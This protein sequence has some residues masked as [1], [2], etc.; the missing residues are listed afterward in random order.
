MRQL[1]S[2]DAQFLN[3]ESATTTGHV[4][5]LV[6][7]DA[8]SAPGGRL[9][10]EDLRD[11]L[12][13][14][15]HLLAPLRQRLVE[16]PLG[17]GWPYW[18]DDPDFDLEYHL[19]EIALPAP[20][21]DEQ[22]AEQ[23]ARVHSWPLDRTR[24]LWE[25]YLVHGLAED[26]QALYTKIHHAAIDG[27]TG[28]EILTVIMDVTPEP[29][30]VEA[31]PQPWLPPPLPSGAEMLQRGVTSLVLQPG[32]LLR[33]LP[34]S[35]PHL[36]DIPGAANV[37]G[38]QA[39]S[40]LADAAL[41]LVTGSGREDEPHPLAA[42]RTPLNGPITAHRRFSFGSVPLADVK[43]VKDAYDLTVNDVVLTL[44][45][46]ALRRWLLDHDALP[47]VPIVV[48]VPVS[49]RAASDD[50]TEGNQISVMVAPLPTNEADP[51]KRL[52]LVQEAMVEAK[53]HFEAVP[54]TILQDLSA[55]IPT[56]LSGLAAR[57]LFQLATA[58]GPPFNLYVSN[59]PGAQSPL[60]VSGARVLGVY[61]L[62]PVTHL[63]GG[64]TVTAFSYDGALD[65]GLI[66]CRELVPDVW[67]LVDYLRDALAELLEL[68]EPSG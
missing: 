44:C 4:G 12:E 60:Y 68:T 14:R 20:G 49:T 31:P 36:I 59:V 51:R 40:D 6:V 25:M 67:N 65:F 42:P 13:Q 23:L 48:A 32:E 18:V 11:L 2:L 15:L 38:A 50:H 28:A 61:P 17:L 55:V 27:L 64:L 35:L 57:A 47:E 39:I 33:T 53:R 52:L 45:T 22:L 56:A 41:R 54:A 34:Q 24:P 29:R 16:V 1:S 37:P 10:L 58:P 7:L 3:I 21:G 9:R 19:R 62:S 66:A 26:R 30:I 8:S 5:G 43:A 63:T 46:A